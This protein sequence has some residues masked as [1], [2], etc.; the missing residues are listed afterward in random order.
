MMQS[1]QTNVKCRYR[2]PVFRNKPKCSHS[3]SSLSKHTP[4]I[5]I[6]L[7]TFLRLAMRLEQRHRLEQRQQHPE[8]QHKV[9]RAFI[10]VAVRNIAIWLF[11]SFRESETKHK[12][13]CLVSKSQTQRDNDLLKQNLITRAKPSIN[14]KNSSTTCGTGMSLS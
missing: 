10:V 8:R 7:Y 14:P 3:I 13:C 5:R 6:Q 11:R 9:Q 4:P 12:F 1:M 2:L